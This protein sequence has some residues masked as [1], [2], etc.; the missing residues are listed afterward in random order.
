M[1]Y[2]ALQQEAR[3]YRGALQTEAVITGRRLHGLE[4]FLRVCAALALVAWGALFC[5]ATVSFLADVLPTGALWAAEWYPLMKAA[6]L[7]LF[8]LW[9]IPALWSGFFT[10]SYF[11]DADLI[12]PESGWRAQA[13]RFEVADI[14]SQGAGEPVPDFFSSRFGSAVALRLGLTAESVIEFL[15]SKAARTESFTI[16]PTNEPVGLAGFADALVRSDEPLRQFLASQKIEAADFVGAA[17]WVSRMEANHKNFLRWWSRDALGRIPGIGKDWAYGET[18]LLTRYAKD[19]LRHPAFF[20][21]R[22][23]AFGKQEMEEIERILSRGREANVLLV[24]E[25]GVPKL[26]PLAL[27]AARI[28]AGTILPPLEHKRIFVFEGAPF[29]AAMKERAVFETELVKLLSE[30]ARAGN[31]IFVFDNFDKFYEGARGIGSDLLSLLDS[32][33]DSPNIQIAAI[34]ETGAYHQLLEPN[35][36]IRER[37]ERVLVAGAGIAGSIPLLEDEAAHREAASGIFFTYPALRVVAE[38]ADRYFPEGVM[39]DK[40]I[41]L[42]SELAPKLA[43]AGKHI[44]RA[45]DVLEL[46]S[47]KTGIA[48]SEAK[49]EERAKLLKLEEILHERVVGQDEAVRAISGA[50]RRA[51]SGISSP[52]RP[53]GSFLFLGPTGVGKTETTKALAEV[54]FGDEKAMTRLD[55][56]EYQ[57][58]DALN[59]LIGT[60]GDGLPGQAGKVG[61]LASLLRE[62]PYGVLLLDEFEKTNKD[63]HDLFLQVLDEGF[64]TDVSGK[65]VNARNLIIIATSNAG[66]DIIWQSLQGGKGLDKDRVITE[67]INR[68][69]FRPEF[70][71]RFDGVILFHPLGAEHLRVIARFQLEKL[72]RRLQGKGLELAITDALLDYLVSIGQD[73]K[74]GARPMNR[75]IQE[76]VEQVIAEKMLRGEAAPGSR[77]ALTAEDLR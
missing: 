59:R 44:A 27:L 35:P 51:R 50:L 6:F 67:I 70:L 19:I 37:F 56:S 42:L 34:A 64:F 22:G 52:N 23:G 38:S 71:N 14:V 55:M 16:T 76:K 39:P 17:A 77:I 72:A 57:S 61:V 25:E 48:V 13:I 45:E 21:S 36:K 9:I 7:I 63:V 65:R 15:Q 24:G 46:V 3:R 2:S 20:A 11:R 58:D 32:F 75:A 40:A 69:I 30:A 43:A 73:P 47:K 29:L 8:G 41:D 4:K 10:S 66:S 49:G 31:I 62:R 12:L 74:F 1:D 28:A 54:F 68:G 5:A 18:A 60:F 53:M 26:A 33:L